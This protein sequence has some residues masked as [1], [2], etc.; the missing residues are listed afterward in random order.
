MT[1]SDGELSDST[2]VTV[3]VTDINDSPDLVLRRELGAEAP[4]GERVINAYTTGDQERPVSVSLGESGF[5]VAW[6]DESGLD[7][8]GYGVFGRFVDPDGVPVGDD[9]QINSDAFIGLAKDEQSHI[10]VD[11]LASGEIIAVW[12]AGTFRTVL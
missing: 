12:E 9:I 1:A 5:F 8:N 3:N 7:G 11:R 6:T 2:S 10:Q 4:S